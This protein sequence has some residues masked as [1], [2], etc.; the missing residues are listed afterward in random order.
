MGGAVLSARKLVGTRV[1]VGG[2]ARIGPPGFL[3]TLIS[4][5]TSHS[6]PHPGFLGF[7]GGLRNCTAAEAGPL[8]FQR[9]GRQ[10]A[11]ISSFRW[12]GLQSPRLGYW[13]SFL[14]VLAKAGECELASILP[15]VLEFTPRGLCSVSCGLFLRARGGEKAKSVV[16]KR[17]TWFLDAALGGEGCHTR[18]CSG[19][20]L[21][22]NSGITLGGLWAIQDVGGG[23]RLTA[24]KGCTSPA[25]LSLWPGF[26]SFLYAIS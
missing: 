12:L 18:W 15:W 19:V 8:G 24:C 21:A 25:G 13:E 9:P 5:G 16:T 6:R 10:L 14:S 1:T 2:A 17:S 23:P 20:L 11:L 22:L 3:L 26:I 4:Q 7:P